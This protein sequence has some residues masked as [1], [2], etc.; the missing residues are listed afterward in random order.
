MRQGKRA[1]KNGEHFTKMIRHTMEEPAWRALSTTAQ[2]L[3]IWLKLEWRGPTA[4]NNGNIRLSVRQAAERLGVTPNTA[5]NAF[6]D[7]QRK[8]FIVLTEF[9]RLGIEGAAKS[10]AWEITELQ[11]PGSGQPVGR[12]LYKSWKP[13]REFPVQKVSANNPRGLNGRRKSCLK[14]EDCNVIKLKMNKN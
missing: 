13:D 1:A 10:S 3:Y 4:N 11:M 8:G 12:K 2:A 14:N 9:A 7:L 6:K 5:A